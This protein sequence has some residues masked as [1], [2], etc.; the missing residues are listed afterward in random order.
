MIGGAVAA[1]FRT[2]VFKPHPASPDSALRPLQLRARRLGAELV[3]AD[4]PALV[5]CWF[6]SD[7]IGLVVGCFSTALATASAVYGLPVAR[8]G[9]ERV[10]R[11]LRPFEN[12][13]R[14][15]VTAID[16]AVPDLAH[17]ALDAD[18]APAPLRNEELAELLQAVGYVMQPTLRP[19]LR[20]STIAW[21][22][23]FPGRRRRYTTRRRMT[24]LDLPGRLPN[25]S[26]S[27]RVLHRVLGSQRYA[28]AARLWRRV[29]RPAISRRLG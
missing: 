17:C 10:L 22:R 19:G 9:T 18:T 1:G 14:I 13:N 27:R 20:E 8:V 3:L 5:E 25:R 12:S 24:E 28:T 16:A 6:G 26:P 7:R 11:R 15:P 2:L 21:C 29:R 23:R 4:T